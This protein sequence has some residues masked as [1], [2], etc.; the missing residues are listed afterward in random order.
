MKA[1][2]L[3]RM[4]NQIT[5]YFCIYPKAEAVDGISKHIQSSWEPRMRNALKAHIDA[6]GEG[7]SPLFLE[8]MTDYFKGPKSPVKAAAR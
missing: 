5:D 8:A 2:D 6:G 4:A 3:V 1:S 7:L